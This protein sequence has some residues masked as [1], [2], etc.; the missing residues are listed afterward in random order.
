MLWQITQAVEQ[1]LNTVYEH[2]IHIFLTVLLF[3]TTY[4]LANREVKDDK[5]CCLGHTGGKGKEHIHDDTYTPC[6]I[7][8]MSALGEA[9]Q[10]ME[11]INREYR[12]TH[13]P[14]LP[15]KL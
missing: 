3:L 8:E 12:E 11:R 13:S 2:Q 15:K 10:K 9:S 14:N 4:A 7:D 5:K 6:E 1:C